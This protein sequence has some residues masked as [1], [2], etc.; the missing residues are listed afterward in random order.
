MAASPS[1]GILQAEP[2]S[3]SVLLYRLPRDNPG[4]METLP[5]FQLSADRR[6]QET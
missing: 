1:S 6:K 3:D 5:G 2:I 4:S